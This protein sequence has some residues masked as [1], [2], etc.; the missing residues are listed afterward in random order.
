MNPIWKKR[1]IAL[2][3]A[4]LAVTAGFAVADE[5]GIPRAITGVA[6]VV[7]A[8][9]AVTRFQLCPL[10]AL[11]PGL[12]VVGY[13]VGNR[14]F[15]QFSL[16]GGLF[17]AAL[18]AEVTLL[19][20]GGLLAVQCAWRG[21]FPM[22]RDLLNVAILAWMAGSSVRLYSDLRNFGLFDVLRDFAVVYYAAFFF[23]AQEAG[24]T[25]A[26]RRFLRQCLVGSC[27]AL[28]VL[29]PLT[30]V[31][32][33][34]F[35]NVFTIREVPL[36]FYKADLA[37]TFMAMGAVLFFLRFEASRRWWDLAISLALILEML[38]GNN[39]AS[40]LG[41]V[42]ATVFL[43]VAGRWQLAAAQALAG[44]TAIA[45]IMLGAL[46]TDTSWQQTPVYGLYER[47][48]SL[49]DPQGLRV[50]ESD[51]AANKGDNN[52]FRAVWWRTVFDE[53]M[54]GGPWLGLGFGHDL[55]ERFVQQ[56]LPSDSDDFSTRSPHN[57]MLTIFGRT[58]F[59][60]LGLFLIV[61]GSAARCTW[62]SLR[63]PKGHD[64]AAHWCGAW[65]ILTSACFGVVL[66]GPMGAVV[67]WT[68][69]GLA[70]AEDTEDSGAKVGRAVSAV[71]RPDLELHETAEVV[72]WSQT[73]TDLRPP[74]D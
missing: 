67:F 30:Q 17:P 33:D 41:L 26:G 8:L 15:A 24:R 64:S 35:L 54:Q 12:A 18:P 40:M 49:A 65:V 57:I 7:M 3:A 13:I 38:A 6:L 28:L 37:G 4:V 58:G 53:T 11:L 25:E 70:N 61:L 34:F 59:V 42:A 5:G 43:L 16:L 45:S 9:F 51:D 39:R 1:L 19:L 50:Y 68:L 69:L 56:Y 46:L 14:G 47:V 32:Q 21:F 48:V 73:K 52:Q 2:G 55:A 44:A 74:A 72:S 31:F 29:W 36:I 10:G 22:R 23:L 62:R 66:E 60:G 27:A 63:M 71:E 20:A